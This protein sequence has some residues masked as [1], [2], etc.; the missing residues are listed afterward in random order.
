[1]S[2]LEGCIA[3]YERDASPLYKHYDSDLKADEG[4]KGTNMVLTFMCTV[5]NYDYMFDLI[6]SMDGNIQVVIHATGLLLLRAVIPTIN[7]PNCIE[8]CKDYIN[9]NAI[10]PVHQHFFNYRID[11]DVDGANNMLTEVRNNN[12]LNR[13]HIFL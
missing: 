4:M 10:A 6:F 8:D 3:V 2:E 9:E 13:N 12:S 1:M 11:F 7:D 5:G